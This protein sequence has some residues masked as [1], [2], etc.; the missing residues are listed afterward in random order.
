MPTPSTNC[1]DRA[2]GPAQAMSCA[3]IS[4]AAAQP[5]ASGTPR[6]RP[7]V[8]AVSPRLSQASRRSSSRPAVHTNSITAQAAMAPSCAITS[9]VN[10][11]W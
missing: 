10:T 3:S 4:A 6:A 8:T 9:G 7:A 5:K 11:A 2:C 1:H